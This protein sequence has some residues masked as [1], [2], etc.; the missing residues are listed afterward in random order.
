LNVA[1]VRA[2]EKNDTTAV[3]ILQEKSPRGAIFRSALLPGWGQWY[4]GKKLKALIVLGGELAI[5]GNAVY[6]N[7][8]VVRSS[9]DF[10]KQYYQYYRNRAFWWLL[11][12][13]L[14]NILDAYVDAH[15][16]NFDTGPDLSLRGE[17][18]EERQTFITFRWAF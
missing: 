14:L 9:S 10:E 4:N 1:N 3:S 8:K 5:V 17:M 7:Q 16:W 2:Q 12:A 13:H 11:A 6:F 18:K 15:L